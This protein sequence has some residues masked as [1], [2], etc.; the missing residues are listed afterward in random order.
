MKAF[1]IET[2]PNKKMI[3]L[4]PE[5]EIKL[6]NMKDPEKIKEKL[7]EAK[8]KQIEKM[9]LNPMTG[10]I[11]SF[12]IFGLNENFYSVISEISDAEEIKLIKI[13]FENLYQTEIITWDGMDFDLPFVYKRA[14]LLNIELPP[15]IPK[16]DHWTKKYTTFPHCDLMQIWNNWGHSQFPATLDYIAKFILRKGKTDRDYSTYV[17][18]IENGEGDKIG[19]DNICDTEL[20]YDIYNVVEKYLF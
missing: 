3:P 18:L 14:L 15:N 8:M 19:I 10:R 6:G 4:L 5:P 7:H 11:C 2:I 20:T 16:L 17:D 1:D 9:G 12:S 13:I